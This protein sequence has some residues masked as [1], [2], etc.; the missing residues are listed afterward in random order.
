MDFGQT[1]L[2]QLPVGPRHLN[3]ETPTPFIVR[4][5]S[6]LLT[7]HLPFPHS[8]PDTDKTVSCIPFLTCLRT[9]TS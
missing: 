7:V 5:F 9:Y 6:F 2:P 8:K 1:K 4:A 3:Q